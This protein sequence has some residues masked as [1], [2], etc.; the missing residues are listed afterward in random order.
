MP[1]VAYTCMFRYPH[2]SSCTSLHLIVS[3]CH[4][5]HILV[6]EWTYRYP[7]YSSCT[8]LHLIVSI[9]H[10]LHMLV[11]ECRKICPHYSSCTRLHLLAYICNGLHC[12]DEYSILELW[13]KFFTPFVPVCTYF[14]IYLFVTKKFTTFWLQE[15]PNFK[16]EI[17]G[18]L[19]F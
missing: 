9:C 4:W 19:K 10:W 6:P 8:W 1:L 14:H 7:Y 17:F 16:N 13:G 5:L 3:I 2:Y 18:E 12:H 15:T 11:P